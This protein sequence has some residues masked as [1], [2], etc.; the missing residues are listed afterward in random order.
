MKK[1]RKKVLTE[2]D[3]YDIQQGAI[4]LIAGSGVA[5]S[6]VGSDQ[7]IK[8]MKLCWSKSTGDCNDVDKVPL[9]RH[10]LKLKPTV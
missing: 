7:F 4:D 6:L 5:L 10:G 9:S 3:I 1:G 8:F 2:E